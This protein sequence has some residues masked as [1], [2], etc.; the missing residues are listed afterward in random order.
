MLSGNEKYYIYFYLL[1][2]LLLITIIF[3]YKKSKIIKKIVIFVTIFVLCLQLFI[4]YN[5]YPLMEDYATNSEGVSDIKK[6]INTLLST[7]DSANNPDY[8]NLNN[9]ILTTAILSG[10][11]NNIYNPLDPAEKKIID[12]INKDKAYE[13]WKKK[14]ENKPLIQGEN[15]LIAQRAKFENEYKPVVTA[16]NQIITKGTPHIIKSL[17]ESIL[18]RKPKVVYGEFNSLPGDPY[19]MNSFSEKEIKM[20][21][22]KVGDNYIQSLQSIVELTNPKV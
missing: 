14:P 17:N 3:V 13:L 19:Y 10:K 6:N 22:T 18:D 2:F 11:L 7:V 15:G 1:S 9:E 12:K 20:L 5:T 21:I 4:V 8:T 16:E